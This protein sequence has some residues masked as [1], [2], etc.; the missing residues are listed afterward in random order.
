MEERNLT[1]GMTGTAATVVTEQNVAAAVGSGDLQVF[2]TPYLL[3]LMEE[4][5]AAA[6]RPH[7]LNGESTVGTMANL[8]HTAATVVGK[9]V[10]ATA[11]LT[12]IDRRKLTFTVVASDEAGEIGRCTHERFIIQT[13]KFLK[14]ASER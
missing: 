6:V 4:A 3:A 1:I 8:V 13:E 5:A 10:C 7:L 2:S 12:D 11:T 9:N 14:K